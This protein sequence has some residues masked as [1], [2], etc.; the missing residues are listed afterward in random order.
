M[1]PNAGFRTLA[2]LYFQRRGY[3]QIFLSHAKAPRRH[4]N[5]NPV[6]VGIEI[7][8]QTSFAGVCVYPYLVRRTSQRY[9]RI[10][11]NRP[12]RHRAEHQ[13]HFKFQLWRK[14]RLQR[15]LAHAARH[16]P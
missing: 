7:P 4:L 15:N 11:R 9:R 8:V 3:P 12:V 14:L 10:V 1:P 16:N 5:D 13:R 6:R 2:Y